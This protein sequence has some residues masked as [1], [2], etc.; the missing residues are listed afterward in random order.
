MRPI[1]TDV[2]VA[3]S[4]CLC[5]VCLSVCLSVCV[6]ITWV[7]CAKMAEPIE[8]SLGDCLTWVPGTTNHVLDGVKIGQIRLQP[9]GVM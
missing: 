6:L 4:L 8:I 3:W 1:A 5:F 7:R 2:Y 9:R